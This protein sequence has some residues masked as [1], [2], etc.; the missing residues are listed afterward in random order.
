ARRYASPRGD[1]ELFQAPLEPVRMAPPGTEDTFDYSA[2]MDL[3]SLFANHDEHKVRD[4]IN[5]MW[6]VLEPGMATRG[7]FFQPGPDGMSIAHA[8]FGPNL[9]LFRHSHPAVGDCLYYIQA[10]ELIMGS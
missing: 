7:V 2:M 3:T 9:Q 4:A 10:G 5:V 8:W 6:R 1:F